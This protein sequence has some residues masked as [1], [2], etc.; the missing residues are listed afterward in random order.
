[1]S[2]NSS[3]PKRKR[4][5]RKQFRPTVAQWRLELIRLVVLL[6]AFVLIVYDAYVSYLGFLKLD[7]GDHAPI[8]FCVLIFVV[9]LGV[10]I[11]HA[12]GEDFSD[13]KGDSG[14]DWLNGAWVSVLWILYGVDIV[15]NAIEFGFFSRF[16]TPLLDPWEQ[17]GGALLIVG[18][19]VGLTFA[20]ETL[21][22]LYDRVNVAAKR[23]HVL[24]RRYRINIQ[25]HH[26]YLATAQ[27]GAIN[28]AEGQGQYEGGQWDFG[29]NL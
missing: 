18:M 2:R 1:M 8:I 19:A 21:M 22:R 28:R 24:S 25:A 5:Y 14:T 26:R 4:N 16:S 10:G 7:I 9:Q 6:T 15:S 12:S 27:A 23:N 20:D 13:V 3:Q 29:E 11:L 17:V